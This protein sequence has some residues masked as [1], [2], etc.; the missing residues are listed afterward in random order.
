MFLTNNMTALSSTAV[1]GREITYW[2]A[3]SIM[4]QPPRHSGADTSFTHRKGLKFSSLQA[5]DFSSFGTPSMPHI[6][7]AARMEAFMRG[8]K[9]EP[10]TDDWL[11]SLK[12]A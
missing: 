12:M 10:V 1:I 4:R 8:E 2:D 7:V 9:R 6:E 5:T 3:L 11:L